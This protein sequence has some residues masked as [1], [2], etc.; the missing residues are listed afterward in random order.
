[1]GF[2][3]LGERMARP[4]NETEDD[5]AAEDEAKSVIEDAWNVTIVKLQPHVYGVDWMICKNNL[6]LHSWGEFKRRYCDMQTYDS[7]ALSLG[8]WLRL[9]WNAE[10]SLL[11]FAIYVQWNDTS[12][13]YKSF[14]HTTGMGYPCKVGGR[15]DRDQTGDEEPMIYIP[16]SEFTPL[17]SVKSS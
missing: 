7:L 17:R 11:P 2:Y 8:K 10:R 9:K 16:I 1:M 14:P 6:S 13:M 12:I 4:K 15:L 3:M 5:L